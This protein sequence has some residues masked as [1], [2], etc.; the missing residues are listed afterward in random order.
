MPRDRPIA[1]VL[2]LDMRTSALLALT[3]LTLALALPASAADKKFKLEPKPYP[4]DTC[5][6]SGEKLGSM[7]DAVVFTEGKQEI[8]LCCSSCRKDFDKDKKANLAK[9]EAASKKVKAYP[10]RHLHRVRRSPGDRQSRGQSSSTVAST[11][12]AARAA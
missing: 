12:S 7:G 6:V 9:I 1:G 4:M 3:T 8:Q 10:A 5:V 11:P 2:P